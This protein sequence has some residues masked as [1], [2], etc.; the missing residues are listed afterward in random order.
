MGLAAF[1]AQG[2]ST[3][4]PPPEKLSEIAT[5]PEWLRLL[6]Y[7]QKFL[8]SAKSEVREAAF[9]ISPF[10]AENP[11]AELVADLAAFLAPNAESVAHGTLRQPAACAFPARLAYLSRVFGEA[12]SSQLP[13]VSC[14]DFE[15]WSRG[16]AARSVSIVFSSA[17]PNNPASMFGHTF[18][19]L[20]RMSAVEATASGANSLSRNSD[21]LSYGAN[22]SASV[23]DHENPVKYA[24][25]GLFGGYRGRYDLT[26]YYRKVAEYGL[27][28][29]RDLWEYRLAFTEAETQFFIQH[30]W[31]LYSDGFFPYYFLD[32]NCSYQILTALEAVRPDWKLSS[33]FILSVLP[34]ET[35]KHLRDTPGAIVAA[36]RRPSLRN[37]LEAAVSVLTNQEEKRLRSLFREDKPSLLDSAEVLDT[38][39]LA[40]TYEKETET[41]SSERTAFMREVLL[42]RSRKSGA[43]LANPRITE[44]LQ[45][46]ERRP[47]DSHP[48]SRLSLS[49]GNGQ[50][51]RFSAFSLSAFAHDF[52]DRPN[53]FNRFSE[54]RLFRF[55]IRE[56]GGD[57]RLDE[58]NLIE[59]ASFA[60]DSLYAPQK[61]WRISTRWVRPKDL[62]ANAN[63]VWEVSGGYG[64]GTAFFNPSQ[65]LYAMPIGSL[66][67]GGRS[68]RKD[69]R[70][71]LGGE[72]GLLLQPF[73]GAFFSHFR[74]FAL[75]DPFRS[76][77]Y[78]GRRWR[79]RAE[80][81]QSVPLTARIDLRLSLAREVR[82]DG[83]N[84]FENRGTLE[85]NFRF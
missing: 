19:R 52:L 67:V 39:I 44:A 50:G 83:V 42:F 79:G 31:E 74:V 27:S 78:F 17:Y 45:G 38:L 80:W 47:D 72:S 65:L 2:P 49:F 64:I 40:L 13:S 5:S 61:S 12:F 69:F 14:P 20:D 62:A 8:R 81:I 58:V 35:V 11:R 23:P 33:G 76:T 7:K 46:D 84:A 9:F 48:S 53:S 29:S 30:L 63:G 75:W 28:E 51:R 37:R 59:M 60:A 22:F 25:W 70:L 73:R 18:L 4:S 56:E 6:H 66:E 41:T 36:T 55:G 32:E 85:A 16:I 54:V 82:T 21:F 3:F 15:S 34:V 43:I 10:G 68:F 1:G 71:G 26:P 57:F 77:V 24:V